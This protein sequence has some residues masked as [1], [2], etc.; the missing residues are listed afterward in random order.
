MMRA[1]VLLTVV[2]LAGGPSF[3]EGLAAVTDPLSGDQVVLEPDG[4]VM[5]LVFFATWCPP[6]VEEL[7]RLTELNARWEGRGYRLVVVGV[8][9]RQTVDRLKSFAKGRGFPGRLL[10][11]GT[12]NLGRGFESEELPAHIVL[13]G[14]GNEVLRSSALDGEIESA[15]DRLVG[16]GRRRGADR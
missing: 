16:G 10:Y 3:A 4:R 15:I 9:R 7:D 11:D 5:H 6:C 13:D 14:K 1:A 12:G 2:L 8:N